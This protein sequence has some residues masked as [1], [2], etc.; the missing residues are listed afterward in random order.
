MFS[1]DDREALNFA[2]LERAAADPRITSIA[3]TGSAAVGQQDRYSDIDLAFAVD[4]TDHVSAAIADFTAFTYDRG[5][6]HHHDVPAG[7][8]IYRVFF[9]PGALQ[10][11]LAF[12]AQA[13]FRPLGPAFKLVAGTAGDP[14]SF[15][16]PTATDLIGLAWL[17]AL[18]AR[19]SILRGKLWQAEYMISAVRDHVLA[20]A[21]LRHNLPTAHARG[22]H[23]LPDYVTAPLTESLIARLDLTELRRAFTVV[24]Q[25]FH[26]EL[27]LSDPVLSARIAGEIQSLASAP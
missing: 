3:V 9:L 21:C 17:H 18:H 15:P 10:V 14:Q 4:N 8:W 7:P 19:T 1:V 13:H 27:T 22:F 6:L 26:A 16:S 2:L 24:L 23:L 5:A 12:V 11:D 25:G 20:L